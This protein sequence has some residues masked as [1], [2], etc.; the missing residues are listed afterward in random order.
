MTMRWITNL[1]T[2]NEPIT[3]NTTLC[4]EQRSKEIFIGFHLNNLRTINYHLSKRRRKEA[5]A[6]STHPL[7]KV[8]KI[9]HQSNTESYQPPNAK[10][11]PNHNPNPNP[12]R[13]PNSNLNPNPKPN[14]NL[15]QCGIP[16]EDSPF[17][18]P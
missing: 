3:I 17:P 11:K 9:S 15:N 5:V 18:H 12:K 16:V 1:T 13:R 10:L 8:K 2:H 14:Y 6:L 4:L 7:D